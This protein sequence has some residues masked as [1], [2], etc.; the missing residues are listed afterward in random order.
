MKVLFLDI[1]GV[2]NTIDGGKSSYLRHG[3]HM[4]DYL[5]KSFNELLENNLDLNI[6]I[7]SSWRDDMEDL[8]FQLEKNGFKFWDRVIGRTVL[9]YEFRGLQILD[10]IN[11]N[12]INEFAV[13]DDNMIEIC[14]DFCKVIPSHFCI[15]TDPKVGLNED[16]ILELKYILN[17]N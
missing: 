5:I 4:E 8:K 9:D 3:N 7:S 12:S 17:L 13:V 11:D 1:D 6:V 16:K 10:F 14:G 15:E 2:L